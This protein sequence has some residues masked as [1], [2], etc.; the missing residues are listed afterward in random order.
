[1]IYSMLE[2]T[3]PEVGVLVSDLGDA[4]QGVGTDQFQPCVSQMI[5]E[6]LQVR[7]FMAFR[8]V[9]ADTPPDII[10]AQGDDRASE[11]IEAYR[12][13]FFRLDPLNRLF[14]ETSPA[15]TY[16]ARVRRDD[17]RNSDYR[18]RCFVRPGIRQKITLARRMNGAWTALSL[19]DFE[20]DAVFDP[21]GLDTL[22]HVA[23]LL[24]PMLNL[25]HRIVD[26][27]P[28]NG[29]VSAAE[30]EERVRWAFPELSNREVSVCA[31]SIVGFTTEG[32]ALDLGIKN[33]SVLT[34]RRRAYARL[35]VNSI[36]QLSTMLIRSSAANHLALAS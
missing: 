7:E 3:K 5:L 24:L 17:I 28:Q 10:V 32:I 29:G 23:N 2:P 26:L 18:N 22:Y 15:G 9:G 31:R 34:Y 25:H 16:I 8:R 14:S 4:I 30:M 27:A 6:T 21:E 1:M 13:H 36:N 33:T 11:R 12:K 19:Y 35:N 20:A